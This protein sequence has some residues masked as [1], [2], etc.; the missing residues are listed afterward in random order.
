MTTLALNHLW[1]YLQSLPMS[2]KDM[3]WLRERINEAIEEKT[4]KKVESSNRVEWL[5]SHPLNLTAEELKD[6]RAQYILSK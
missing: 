2:Y 5:R 3:L 1:N 4:P 6:D